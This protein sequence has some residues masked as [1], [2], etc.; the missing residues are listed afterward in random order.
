M[1]NCIEVVDEDPCIVLISFDMARY[2]ICFLFCPFLDAASYRSHL[3]IG[4][5][6]ADDEIVRRRIIQLSQVYLND[7]LPLDVRYRIND[8]FIYLIWSYVLDCWCTT[9]YR[10]VIIY[11]TI[12][13]KRLEH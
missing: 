9:Q 5:P 6:F 4:R 10:G 11:K 7:F 13:V 8:Q 2:R 1:N 3:G 12:N